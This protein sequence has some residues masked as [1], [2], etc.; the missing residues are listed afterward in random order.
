MPLQISI[1]LLNGSYDAADVEDRERAEWPPHPARLY[2]ALVAAARGEADRDALRWLEAQAAPTIHAGG[3]ARPARHDSYVVTNKLSAKG[4]S[5]FHLGRTNALK[6]RHWSVPDTPAVTMTW[7]AEAAPQTVTA[8][9]QMA[10]R[11]PYLGRSTG[12][13]LVVASATDDT[14]AEDGRDRFEPCDMLDR[15][16]LV[17]VPYAGFLDALDA[18]FEADKPAWEVSRY[19]PYHRKTAA[20]VAGQEQQAGSVY[21]DLLGFTF[22]GMKPEARLAIRF[23]E[24]LRSAVLKSAGK[25]A[26]TVLHGHRA[27]GRPHVA[28]LALPD[29]GHRH[30]D[31]HLLGMAVAIPDLPADE[32]AVTIRSVL[33]LHRKTENDSDRTVELDVP[34]I[35]KVEMTRLQPDVIRP[36]GALP[37]RWRRGS[38]RW[39]SATPVVL[40]RYPKKPGDVEAEIVASLRRVGLPEPCDIQISKDPLVKGG[41]RLRPR[42]L[43]AHTRGRLF[44]HVDVTFGQTVNGPVLVGAGRYLGVGLLAPKDGN[45]DA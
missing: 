43:P 34:M 22:C 5:Q 37:D 21:T 44:R 45:G 24:A 33:G 27:D 30:A 18:Q 35:G 12:I 11:I 26:P 42:D 19:Q 2:C 25:A 36:W 40:D 6:V 3:T 32:R 20:V 15:E 17:R 38:R 29:V 41:A 8:L 14:A 7:Q 9:D 28:F 23:T 13:A 1:E 39:A 16:T 4:S 31:G 10:R